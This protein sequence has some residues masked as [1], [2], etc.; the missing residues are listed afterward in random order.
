MDS[1]SVIFSPREKWMLRV[2]EWWCGSHYYVDGAHIV[3]VIYDTKVLLFWCN[4]G[5]YGKLQM[6]LH[7]IQQDFMEKLQEYVPRIIVKMH[8]SCWR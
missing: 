4:P 7:H 8:S 6:H 5:V 1:I 2:Q 3:E